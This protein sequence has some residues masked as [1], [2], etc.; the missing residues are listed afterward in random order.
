MLEQILQEIMKI[1]IL[2]KFAILVV[3]N[4][5]LLPNIKASTIIAKVVTKHDIKVTITP[6]SSFKI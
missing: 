4:I 5:F 6:L 3:I 1:T 2:T